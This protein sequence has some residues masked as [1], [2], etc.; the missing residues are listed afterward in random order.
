MLAFPSS[1]IDNFKFIL[2]VSRLS[3]LRN[4]ALTPMS[5]IRDITRGNRGRLLDVPNSSSTRRERE[6]RRGA[7]HRRATTRAFIARPSRARGSPLPGPSA[8]SQSW[9]AA[10]TL[11]RARLRIHYA[12][13]DPRPEGSGVRDGRVSTFARR[14]SHR[15]SRAAG[16]FARSPAAAN[17]SG[18]REFTFALCTAVSPYSPGTAPD[19][20]AFSPP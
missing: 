19:R 15:L 9:S 10:E 12:E 1:C 17:C 8:S 4:R 6:V 2:L 18:S 11:S 20:H 5:C 13:T 14:T 7:A 3:S 16:S